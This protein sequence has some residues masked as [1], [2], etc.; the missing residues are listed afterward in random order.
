M[1]RPLLVLAAATLL[2]TCASPARAAVPSGFTDDPVAELASPTALAPTPDGRLLLTTQ[3]GELRVVKGGSLLATPALRLPS[4]CTDSERGLLGVAVAADFASSGRVFLYYTHPG[5]AGCAHNVDGAAVNRV[6][7][8]TLG[9]DDRIDPG[10][11]RVLL[12]GIPSPNGNHNGGDLHVGPDGL[13][14]V[15]VGDG[16]CDY[17][18]DSGCAGANDAARDANT[19][20]G[21]LLR[22][23]ADGSIPVSNP[24]RGPGTAR[25][26]RGPVATGLA[27]QETWA[28]GLRNPFRFAI[29]PTSPASSP[30]IHIDDV[31]QDR[32]EEIDLGAARADFGWNSR[33]GF[34]ANGS[35]TD[36]G[37]PPAGL[38]NPIFA[39]GHG[40]GCASITGGAFLPASWPA[41]YGGAYVFGDF[42]CGQIRRLVPGTG[43][44]PATDAAFATGLGGSS[45]TALA[46]VPVAGSVPALYYLTYAGGGQIRRIRPAQ[47]ANTAPTAAFTATPTSGDAPLDVRFDASGSRDRDGDALSY[48]WIFGDG[49]RQTTGSPVV[50]HRYTRPGSFS[51]VLQLADA[52]GAAAPTRPG[53]KIVVTGRAPTVA[54]TSPSLAANF[55]VGQSV[56]LHADARDVDGRPLPASALSWTVKLHHRDHDHPY[57]ALTGNDVRVSFPAPEGFAATTTSYLAAAVAVR[58]PQGRTASATRRIQARRVPLRVSTEPAGLTVSLAGTAVKGPTDLTS[59][60]GWTFDVSAA[61]QPGHPFASWSDGGAATHRYVTPNKGSA[62]LTARFR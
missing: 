51:A 55:A 36:C 31:G 18:R 16:G 27:C 33:E 6:S 57:A 29:D 2:A 26:D 40:S 5:S 25:C 11:E 32:W 10:S 53:R 62:Q 22:I 35:T 28:R 59:W 38:T 30:R 45:V 15:S 50:S 37:A 19:P 4:L 17:R 41:P 60:A 49:S 52:R 39:Y 7:S 46:V 20:N 9:D 3:P 21:K 42:V 23:A 14:Y 13:L 24:F 1:R 48:T 34:C 8:F 58:D 56:V 54:I 43:G 47:A 12:D 44:A 61:S